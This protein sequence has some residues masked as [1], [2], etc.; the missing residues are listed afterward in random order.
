M[1]D[2]IVPDWPAPAAVRALITT[3]HGGVSGGAC[4][5]LNLALHVG[6]DPAA[7]AE[8]RARLRRHLP[9]E[10]LWLDQ[11][12]GV[13]VVR[14]DQ[15]QQGAR[16]DGSVTRRRGTVCAVMTA[17]CLPLL[18]C[19]AAGSVVGIAHAGWR[20]L[21]AGV[22]EATVRAMEQPGGDLLAYL[23]RP[24]ARHRSKSVPKCERRS[25]TT[26]RGRLPPSWRQ[27]RASSS[28]TST[29]WRGSG[30]QMPVCVPCS[31]AAPTPASRLSASF[32]SAATVPAAAWPR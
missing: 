7:V 20:G 16:A 2:W 14:A 4:A 21:A 31:V 23:G 13:T 27:A 10:P 25:S 18:L 32:H 6:D 19:D 24:S 9:D 28:P 12:H 30:W 5:S 17:D 8:N 11:V 26:M 3:R 1:H 29:S 22:I 15:V